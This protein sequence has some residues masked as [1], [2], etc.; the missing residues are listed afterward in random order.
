MAAADAIRRVLLL[1]R[2]ELRRIPKRDLLAAW[3]AVL[4]LFPDLHPENAHDHG[5]VTLSG[6][7]DPRI[8]SDLSR[9]LKVRRA[10]SG[11]P[12]KLTE[13]GA[14]ALRR[15]E[16]GELEGKDLYRPPGRRPDDLRIGVG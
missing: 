13:I 5:D 14:E 11:W 3:Y 16:V 6:P 7:T 15:V 12:A 4:E 9:R 10:R 8:P 2:K 1:D